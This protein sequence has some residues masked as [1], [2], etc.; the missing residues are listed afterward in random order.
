MT[1]S[2]NASCEIR[3][4]VGLGNPG[5]SYSKTRHNVGFYLLDDYVCSKG[6][7]WKN[8]NKCNG[9]IAEIMVANR[10]KVYCLK[11]Q[12]FINLS[13]NAVGAFCAYH[14]IVPTSV[15][16]VCDDVS[17]PFGKFKVST[18]PGNAGHNGIKNISEVFGDGFSRYRIGVGIKPKYIPL[19]DFVLGRFS[20]VESSH[21]S[22]IAQTFKNNIEVLIDKGVTK[23]L[24]FIERQKN[25]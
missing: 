10:Q 14:K 23:G 6:G 22:E 3:L 2:P 16:V 12:T 8:D 1:S 21:L 20:D 19:N 5:P 17:I 15:M 11:P 13:G 24:N 4:L 7:T 9:L 18:I 25:E